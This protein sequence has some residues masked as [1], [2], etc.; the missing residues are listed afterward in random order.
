VPLDSPR[1]E[2]VM[3]KCHAQLREIKEIDERS[4]IEERSEANKKRA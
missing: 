3:E 2:R 4:E 1:L